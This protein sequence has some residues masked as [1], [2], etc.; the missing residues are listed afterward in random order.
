MKSLRLRRVAVTVG[1]IGAL[2]LSAVLVS[3]SQAAESTQAVEVSISG[4]IKVLNSNDTAL[5]E[6]FVNVPAVA[7][8][9]YHLTPIWAIEGEF[10]WIIP[11]K[12]SVDLGAAS[13]PDRK[14]PDILTYQ[15]S[16]LAKLP[17][18]GS[19]WTPYLSAGA[20]AMTFLSNTDADRLPRLQDSQ[21]VFAI[22]FGAGASYGFGSHWA[23]RADF[24]EFG[25]FPADD[26]Q[27]LSAANSADPIWMERGTVGVAYRF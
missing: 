16:V 6:A 1:G 17:L 8:V 4:G 26:A 15:A 27:G 9:T 14:N 5:P 25:A 24:R 22:S 20:G 11:I 13:S 7:A 2:A 21:T 12:Q 3:G 18:A 19:G 23:L 10:A